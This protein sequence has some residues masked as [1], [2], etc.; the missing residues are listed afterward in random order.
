MVRSYGNQCNSKKK[1][2]QTFYNACKAVATPTCTA[3]RVF[4]YAMSSKYLESDWTQPVLTA[5][6]THCHI[7]TT[8]IEGC[9]TWDYDDYSFFA[10]TYYTVV[11]VCPCSYHWSGQLQM[12]WYELQSESAIVQHSIIC[13]WLATIKLCCSSILVRFPDFHNNEMPV[14]SQW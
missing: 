10:N 6:T 8:L 3:N 5:R 7:L 12:F 1:V 4:L 14:S 2:S 11:M 13:H 9:G